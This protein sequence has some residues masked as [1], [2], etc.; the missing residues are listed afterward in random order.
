[1]L[2]MHIAVKIPAHGPSSLPYWSY[3]AAAA[4]HSFGLAT[5]HSALAEPLPCHTSAMH[6]PGLATACSALAEPLPRHTSVTA[7]AAG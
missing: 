5:A 1:M 2:V 7:D 6:S 4:M 3:Q